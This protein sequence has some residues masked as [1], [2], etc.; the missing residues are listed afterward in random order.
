[1]L[2]GHCVPLKWG[3][4]VLVYTRQQRV[5]L[6]TRD[7]GRV[8]MKKLVFTLLPMRFCEFKGK[9]NPQCCLA[10]TLYGRKNNLSYRVV[11]YHTVLYCIVF[12]LKPPGLTEPKPRAPGSGVGRVFI[13]GTLGFTSLWIRFCEFRGKKKIEKNS[14]LVRE[15]R[16]LSSLLL[17]WFWLYGSSFSSVNSLGVKRLRLK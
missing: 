3:Y 15:N 8:F 2:K 16:E 4:T 13:R 6:A 10:P 1:M 11:P 12:L 5:L 9:K 7:V 17:L 14:A